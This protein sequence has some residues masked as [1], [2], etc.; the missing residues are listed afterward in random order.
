MPRGGYGF[1]DLI[2]RFHHHLQL[3]HSLPDTWKVLV[4][5]CVDMSRLVFAGV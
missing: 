5:L 1:L 4:G 2:Q 3:M